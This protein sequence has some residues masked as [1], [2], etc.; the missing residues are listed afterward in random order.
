MQQQAVEPD[1]VLEDLGEIG[2]SGVSRDA[3]S[4][5]AYHSRDDDALE[6]AAFVRGLIVELGMAEELVGRQW[7]SADL[8][9]HVFGAAAPAPSLHTRSSPLSSPRCL[10]GSA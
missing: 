10:P 7:M 8:V 1:H 2:F 6:V 4:S 5:R 9:D 3:G